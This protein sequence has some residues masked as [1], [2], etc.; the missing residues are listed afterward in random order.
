MLEEK[1]VK[2]S[3]IDRYFSEYYKKKMQ[4]DDNDH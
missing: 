2:I 1:S 3:E 4:V